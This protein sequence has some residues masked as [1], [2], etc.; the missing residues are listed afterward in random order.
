MV[1]GLII[2]NSLSPI[3]QCRIIILISMRILKP[4]VEV[5]KALGQPKQLELVCVPNG[6]KGPVPPNPHNGSPM[7]SGRSY[8]RWRKEKFTSRDHLIWWQWRDIQLLAPSQRLGEKEAGPLKQSNRNKT[9]LTLK[10]T[11]A[12]QCLSKV[13]SC[14]YHSQLVCQ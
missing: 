6:A 11:P 14:S 5:N 1:V 10:R 9:C 12:R 4:G 2:W 7:C 13:G 8:G 3:S